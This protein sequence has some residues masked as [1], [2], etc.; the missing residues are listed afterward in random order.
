MAKEFRTRNFPLYVGI[1]YQKI[2]I[3]IHYQKKPLGV[4]V[5]KSFY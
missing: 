3:G 1:H 2:D 4:V 5:I